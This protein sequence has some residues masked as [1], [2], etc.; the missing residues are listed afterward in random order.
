MFVSLSITDD[1]EEGAFM[2]ID[3][4]TFEH[5]EVA[6]LTIPAVTEVLEGDVA[7]QADQRDFAVFADVHSLHSLQSVVITKSFRGQ[8]LGIGWTRCL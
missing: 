6:L 1:V 5:D 7:A 3:E 8:S 2:R 4:G